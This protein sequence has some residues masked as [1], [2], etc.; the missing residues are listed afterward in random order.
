[1]KKLP[2]LTVLSLFSLL[3]I[4]GCDPK[5]D[6]TPDDPNETGFGL[7]LRDDDDMSSVPAT[8]NFGFGADNLPESYDILD[9]FPPTG[10]QG[11]YG[12]CVA[13][14]VGYN[15]KTVINGIEKGYNAND[16][17]SPNKQFSPK[18]LF[19]A[20]DDNLKG[21]DC[22]GSNFE[23]ALNIIQNRGI[24]TLQTVPYTSLGNC[25]QSGLDPSWATEAAGNKI[26][27]WR[28]VEGSVSAIK[29][30]ISQNVPV[31]FG[32]KLADN[33]MSHNSDEV[34]TSA[35]SYDNVGQH[36]Y[37]ALII[38]GYDDNKGPN[39]AFR[40]VN[41][42]G[43]GWG[44]SGNCWV[45][46]NFFFN[47]FVMGE[48]NDKVL[49]IAANEGGDN[50]PDPGPNPVVSG[51][52]LAP[53]IFNDYSTGN[54]DYPT[55]RIL[56]FNIYNIG[57][58]NASS[59]ADW[60]YYHIYYNA[61]DANDYGVI[62]YDQF[63][64]SVA[65]NTYNCPTEWNCIFNIPIPAGNNFAN[66][67]WGFESVTRTYYMPDIT[68]YYYLLTIADAEDKFQEE[69]EI[70][71]LFYTSV[72]PIYFDYGIGTKSTGGNAGSFKFKNEVP[73]SVPNLR[74]SKYN[75][76]VT[77]EFKNAYTQKEILAF[78]KAEKKSGRLDQKVDEYLQRKAGY[79]IPGKH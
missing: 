20:I 76:V 29:K 42:W 38:G 1:M 60:S 27:Y 68:G 73:A 23:D 2:F 7:G 69:N 4:S 44:S 63:N 39:G 41:S 21:Q 72:Y 19:T 3:M 70:N 54:Y 37:H 31:I 71:N 13:W 55:E 28:K 58:A 74:N 65:E 26:A 64:T 11:Q 66:Y 34:I 45:D 6:D 5:D 78:F 25:S 15:C 9:K 77:P 67:A 57:N 30:N 32:A 51:V 79:R 62:F 16:L 50:P 75:S 52:D 22:G 35:T 33:F 43:A 17:A 53:W 12:T 8:T 40:V 24:A 61:Y 56:D 36:A 18:D 14:A 48:G 49:F 46:Y 10:D 47:E 59:S